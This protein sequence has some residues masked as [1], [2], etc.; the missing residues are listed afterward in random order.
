[1]HRPHLDAGHDPRQMYLFFGILTAGLLYI[2]YSVYA[3]I[4]QA[5]AEVRAVLPF[6][7]LGVALIIALGFEFVNGFHDTANAVATMIY[8]HS[9]PAQLAVMW[10]GLFNVLGAW[11]A[12]RS[13]RWPSATWRPRARVSRS[14]PAT[15]RRRRSPYSR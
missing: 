2:A 15:C 1:V 11:R 6:I 13:A 12:P 3:D 14:K 4:A 7:L 8:T 9:L 10:S 5:G